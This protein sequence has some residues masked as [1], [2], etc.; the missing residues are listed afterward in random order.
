MD[1]ADGKIQPLIFDRSRILPF[2]LNLKPFVYLFDYP[3]KM[4]AVLNLVGNVTMFAPLGI[5]WPSVFKKLN[6]SVKVLGAGM[7]FSLCIELFQL[8]FC[9]RATDI[10]D[11]ILNTAGFAMGYGIYLLVKLICRKKKC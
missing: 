10:Y 6:G 9:E 11:L 7:G 3:S 5:V 2:R 4:E 8:L 1:R